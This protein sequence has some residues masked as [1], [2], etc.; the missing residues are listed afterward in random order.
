MLSDSWKVPSFEAPSPKK[1]TATWPLLRSLADSAAP[2]AIG[3]PGA[4]DAVGAQDAQLRPGDVHGAAL[5][6]AVA[7]GLAVQLGHHAAHLAA[8]GDDVAVAAVGAGDVV[9]VVEG[10]AHADRHR[11]LAQVQVHE[12]GQL[13]GG[14][15]VLDPV[16]RSGGSSA[17]ARTSERVY[18]WGFPFASIRLH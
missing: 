13:A 12:A 18:L 1:Q 3:D 10:G 5:A 7:G 15:Q 14:E 8:L 6:L 9:V 16:S 11:L 17:S 2:V 4:D